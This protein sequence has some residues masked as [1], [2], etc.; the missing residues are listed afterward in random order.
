MLLG[1]R[2]ADGTTKKL[3]QI[4]VSSADI[5]NGTLGLSLTKNEDAT[6]ELAGAV[7]GLFGGGMGG[8]G[9]FGGGRRAAATP[10]AKL[11]LVVHTVRNEDAKSHRKRVDV[12]GLDALTL[13]LALFMY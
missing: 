11:D 9:G 10:S 6:E 7:G 4:K 12:T 2:G 3:A 1:G 8:L 5:A 13:G